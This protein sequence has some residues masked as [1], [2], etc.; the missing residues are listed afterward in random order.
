[1]SE[2]QIKTDKTTRSKMKALPIL[3]TTPNYS[4]AARLIGCSHEQ[5]YSW[6][7]DE[8]FKAEL[9]KLRS[10]LVNDAISKMKGY[11]TKA[12]DTLAAL[13]DD[14][15]SQVRRAACNDILN[16]VG[17]F[18]ELKELETRLDNLEKTVK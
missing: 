13:M 8:E 2:K 16:H 7:R 4:E 3:A 18:I 11:V 5:I 17:R 14:E 9:E 15:S 6:L 1:M 12:V 10:H